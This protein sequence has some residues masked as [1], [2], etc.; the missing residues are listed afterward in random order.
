MTPRLA[1]KVQV[2]ALIRIVEG[3]GGTGMVVRRG[4]AEAGSILLWLAERGRFAGLLERR[5]NVGG[6]YGWA[7]TGPDK[8]QSLEDVEA[9]LARRANADPDL[10]VVELDADSERLVAELTA[11]G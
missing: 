6:D 9:Y 2:S 10:W 1:A 7:S 11:P 4:D 3:R 8:S 5:L